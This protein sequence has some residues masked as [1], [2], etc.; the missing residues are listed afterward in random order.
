MPGIAAKMHP[1]NKVMCDRYVM[2][3]CWCNKAFRFK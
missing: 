3:E 1:G 2:Q